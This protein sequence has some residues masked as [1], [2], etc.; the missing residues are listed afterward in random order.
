MRASIDGKSIQKYW[1]IEAHLNNR[2]WAKIFFSTPKLKTHSLVSL[3][4]T[5]SLVHIIFLLG[6]SSWLSW[7]SVDTI[8]L[9]NLYFKNSVVFLFTELYP[10]TS[11]VIEYFDRLLLFPALFAHELSAYIFSIWKLRRIAGSFFLFSLSFSSIFYLY[12][13]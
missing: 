7:L 12:F 5:K 9:S 13:L 11:K 10:D 2:N 4:L 1:L 6:F 3:F 8:L